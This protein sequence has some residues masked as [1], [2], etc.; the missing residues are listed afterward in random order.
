MTVYKYKA[1]DKNG[2][3]FHGLLESPNEEKARK[4]LEARGFLVTRIKRYNPSRPEKRDL[5]EYLSVPVLRIFPFLE[6]PAESGLFKEENSHER[7]TPGMC[8]AAVTGLSGIILLIIQKYLV[9]SLFLICLAGVLTLIIHICRTL[10]DPARRFEKNWR[11]GFF[12]HLLQKGFSPGEIFRLF[13]DNIIIS[14]TGGSLVLY[15]IGIILCLIVNLSQLDKPSLI[16]ETSVICISILL[17][18]F[19][20]DSRLIFLLPKAQVRHVGDTPF[21]QN[22]NI[23]FQVSYQTALQLLLNLPGIIIG[24]IIYHEIYWLQDSPAIIFIP[25]L[26]MNPI[27]NLLLLQRTISEFRQ[28]DARWFAAAIR[29]LEEQ[30]SKFQE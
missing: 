2:K 5:A 14:E 7:I 28:K 9:I 8:L 23:L 4:R 22:M 20:I 16:L 1:H 30:T 13:F 26:L 24:I 19:L 6:T 15:L 25:L 27:I 11:K 29:R 17:N 21:R 3:T 10:F 18:L 12:E